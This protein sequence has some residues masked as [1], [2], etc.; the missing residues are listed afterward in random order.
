MH[1]TI[2]TLQLLSFF[3]Y[4]PVNFENIFSKYSKTKPDKLT[5]KELWN[6]T[7]GNRVTFGT[8]GWFVLHILQSIFVFL[9]NLISLLI[10]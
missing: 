2:S 6:L 8:I 5:L 4:L 3:R 1:N 9:H 10:E 7:D